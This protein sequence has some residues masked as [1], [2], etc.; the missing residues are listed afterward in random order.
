MMRKEGLSCQV[1]KHKQK[2]FACLIDYIILFRWRKNYFNGILSGIHGRHR[3]YENV[4]TKTTQPN[5][6]VQQEC[7]D[8][9]KGWATVF[10]VPHWWHEGKVAS[11]RDNDPDK[12]N[13][14]SSDTGRRDIITARDVFKSEQLLKINRLQI[15]RHESLI[16]WDIVLN[17]DLWAW[18]YPHNFISLLV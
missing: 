3:I 2:Y 1:F 8:M 15:N 11:D 14:V 13:T 7:G 17:T 6:H 12:T 10:Y 9:P 16:H 5:D 4:T 18:I